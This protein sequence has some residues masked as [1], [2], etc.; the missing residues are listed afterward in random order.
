VVPPKQSCS[1][2][3]ETWSRLVSCPISEAVFVELLKQSDAG[4]HLHSARIID[5]LSLGLALVPGQV[6]MAT[7][8]AHFFT[9]MHPMARP[10]F[11]P[12][13]SGS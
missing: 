2:G 8:R 6:R 7:E 9:A 4:S 5:E 3:Y 10:T 1:S 11:I 13:I 12:F